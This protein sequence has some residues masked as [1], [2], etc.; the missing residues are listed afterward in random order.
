MNYIRKYK[1]YKLLGADYITSDDKDIIFFVNDFL[2]NIDYY[3]E[4][5]CKDILG[6]SIINT[7]YYRKE[8][9]EYIFLFS[10]LSNHVNIRY[11]MF[12]REIEKKFWKFPYVDI[13][14]F[15]IFRIEYIMNVQLKR[16]NC[17]EADSKIYD[18]DINNIEIKK[19]K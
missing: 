2:S 9:D 3:R 18:I 1:I 10:I 15:I 16:I 12:W 11:D 8:K 13:K 19:Y 7:F 14:K 4:E 6:N 5:N 17:Y